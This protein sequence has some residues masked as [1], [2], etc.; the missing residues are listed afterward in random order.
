MNQEGQE[1]E[2]QEVMC[3]IYSL[4]THSIASLTRKLYILHLAIIFYFIL[5]IHM[6]LLYYLLKVSV[7]DV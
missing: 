1:Q 4:H 2:R 3:T 7:I 5:I 6:L